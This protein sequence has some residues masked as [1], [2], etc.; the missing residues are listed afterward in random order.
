L[1][2]NVSFLVLLAKAAPSLS[3]GKSKCLAR[4]GETDDKQA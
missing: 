2:I 3:M 1:N 4:A